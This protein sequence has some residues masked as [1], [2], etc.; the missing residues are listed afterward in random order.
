MSEDDLENTRI[1]TECF[2]LFRVTHIA[3]N[4]TALLGGS[5]VVMGMVYY[6]SF[7]RLLLAIH[8]ITFP[9]RCLMF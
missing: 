8:P 4:N 3:G 5:S 9:I 7:I 2:L 6:I 1:A